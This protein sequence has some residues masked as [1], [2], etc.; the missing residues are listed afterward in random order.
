GDVI[1]KG[2]AGLSVANAGT[3]EGSVS[4]AQGGIITNGVAGSTAARIDGFSTNITGGAGSIANYG[5]IFGFFDG[6][7]LSAGGSVDNAQPGAVITTGTAG[8]DGIFV[9]GVTPGT[10]TNLGTVE[11]NGS[12]GAAI[13]LAT[14]GGTATNGSPSVTSAFAGF[15]LSQ[16]GIGFYSQPAATVTNFAT[17]SAANGIFLNA[18]GSVANTGTAAQIYGRFTGLFAGGAATIDNSGTIE[19]VSRYGIE[20]TSGSIVNGSTAA[21][22]ASIVADRADLATPGVTTT[23]TA[24]G[25]GIVTSGSLTNYGSVEGARAGVYIKG[26]AFVVNGP[27]GAAAALLEGLYAGLATLGTSTGSV[28]LTNFG[29]I[30][31]IG[32]AGIGVDLRNIGDNT[33]SNSGTISG[34]G[35]TAVA[36]GAGEDLMIVRP[37]AAF[38]GVVDGG[39]GLNEIDFHTAGK[40]ALKFSSFATVRLATGGAESLAL[41]PLNLAG[42]PGNAIA[43][44]DGKAGDTVS[45][46][47]LTAGEEATVAGGA[48][49]DLFVGGPGKEIFTGGAGADTFDFSAAA[50]A[51]SDRVLGGT[52]AD[53]LVMTNAGTIAASGVGG[54]ETWRLANGKPSSLQLTTANFTGTTGT[55]ITVIDG[56][57]GDTVS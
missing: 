54:V 10:V 8:Q 40:I 23:S 53:T 24:V 29:T 4:L 31:G 34:A 39:A 3:I 51:V 32:S 55:A 12:V 9:G 21:T 18:G 14:A 2:S 28:T 6:V 1:L 36:F 25:V 26:S 50:L 57:A 16:A 7:Y 15:A 13:N 30:A 46:H 41:Q 49:N 56:N 27:S 42:L 20:L 33:L 35:G 43:V 52:G 48:G 44:I 5:T 45:A 22:A 47:A 17:F 38:D 37:G 11:V 19:A